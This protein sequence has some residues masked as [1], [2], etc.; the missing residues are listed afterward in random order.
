MNSANLA[1]FEPLVFY[2][3]AGLLLLASLL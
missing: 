1:V 2:G 3:F